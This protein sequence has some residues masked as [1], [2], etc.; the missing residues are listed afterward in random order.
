MKKVSFDFTPIVAF[1]ALLMDTG[2]TEIAD[3][4]I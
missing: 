2:K 4:K 1:L 3:Y